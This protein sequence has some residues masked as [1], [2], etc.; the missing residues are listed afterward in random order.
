MTLDASSSSGAC[1][2]NVE[3]MTNCALGSARVTND[4]SASGDG[5][6][7]SVS[8]HT[9]SAQLPNY[10]PKGECNMKISSRY[11]LPSGDGSIVVTRDYWV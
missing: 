9:L 10:L 6:V 5:G 8:S 4:I 1:T 7:P 11:N 3:N 2:G